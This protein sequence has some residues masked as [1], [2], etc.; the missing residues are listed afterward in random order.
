MKRRSNISVV[1]RAFIA[2]LIVGIVVYIVGDYT[3]MNEYTAESK[4]VCGK[5]DELEGNSLSETY[6]ATIDSNS[7]RK[8]V[9]SNLGLDRSGRE[10]EK[11]L[12]II[13]TKATPIISIKVKDTNKLRAEDLADEYADVSVAAI[14]K[15][16]GGSSEVL[17]YA[18]PN[19][20]IT[21]TSAQKAIGLGGGV[22]LLWILIGLCIVNPIHNRKVRKFE[23]REEISEE[24]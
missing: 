3:N 20:M 8:E 12:T 1:A 7:I 24:E 4:I 10:I 13:P 21:Y 14:N 9:L 18:Y 19:A 2:A 15:L 16:Y 22:F 17:E 6:A 23:E 11:K 5:K